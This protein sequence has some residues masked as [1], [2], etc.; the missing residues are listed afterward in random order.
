MPHLYDTYLL[1]EP[2]EIRNTS[3]VSSSYDWRWWPRLFQ[4][5]NISAS[6]VDEDVAGNLIQNVR[7][8]HRFLARI[9]GWIV[10]NSLA[11]FLLL[12]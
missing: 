4:Y 10:L 12:F 5:R 7:A 11:K 9:D 2:G 8:F 6:F 3:S 1:S